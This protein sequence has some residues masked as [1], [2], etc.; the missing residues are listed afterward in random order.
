MPQLL[1]VVAELG[2]AAL[3]A[4][5]QLGAAGAAEGDDCVPVEVEDFFL[6]VVDNNNNGFYLWQLLSLRIVPR[7]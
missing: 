6:T 7:D 3:P 1:A 2:A 4:T 5:R